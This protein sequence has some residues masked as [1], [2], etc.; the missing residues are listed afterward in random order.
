[1]P[2]STET[3]KPLPIFRP[4]AFNFQDIRESADAYLAKVKSEAA[5]IAAETKAEIERLRTEI[6]ADLTSQRQVLEIKEKEIL[7]RE[8]KVKAEEAKLGDRQKTIET[9]KYEEAFE[10]GKREGYDAGFKQGYET[11]EKQA[12]TDYNERLSQECHSIITNRLETLFP[13]VQAAVSQLK[14]S[15][16]MFL[17]CWEQQTVQLAAT[18]ARQTIS[19]E[20]PNM[21]D[22]PLKLLREALE[23]AIGSVRLKIRMNPRDVEFLEPEIDRLIRQITPAAETEIVSDIRISPGGCYLETSQGMIDQRLESR[24]AR[25]QEELN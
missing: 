5:R 8:E 2:S 22:V 7:A 3:E 6:S 13:A 15:E 18:I 24:L 10:Q 1:M 19:R 11:G 4:V 14:E 23:L 17:A 16:A 12:L 25:I 21:A 20:L 9:A